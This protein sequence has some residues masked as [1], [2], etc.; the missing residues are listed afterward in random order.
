MFGLKNRRKK[1]KKK[2]NPY[3]YY[4]V[5]SEKHT[6][7]YTDRILYTP[8]VRIDGGSAK[9]CEDGKT[10]PT[11]KF[12]VTDCLLYGS[13]DCPEVSGCDHRP[14]FGIYRIR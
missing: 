1:K 13:L 8:R 6:P 7:S 9:V 2:F 11:S 12:G 3:E 4:N 14:V 10:P 5:P